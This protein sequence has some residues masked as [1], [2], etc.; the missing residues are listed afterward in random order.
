MLSRQHCLK[1]FQK[2]CTKFCSFAEE[3][4]M[5]AMMPLENSKEMKWQRT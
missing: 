3:V 2:K 1:F 4:S 5:G